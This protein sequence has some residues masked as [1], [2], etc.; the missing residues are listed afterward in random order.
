MKRIS[1]LR[2]EK[3]ITQ[4]KLAQIIGIG[5][6]TLAMYETGGSEPDFATASKL[7]DYFGV[8]VDYL[9]GRDTLPANMQPLDFDFVFVPN[10]ADLAAGFDK[11]A[12]PSDELD[13]IPIPRFATQGYRKEELA[14]FTVKGDSMY[15]DF[16]H[17][18]RILV[19]KQDSVDSGDTAVIIYNNDEATIKKVRYESGQDWLELIPRNPEYQTKRI[20][21][22]DLT[23][24]R[25]I[26]KVL[27]LVWRS[28]K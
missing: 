18:D 16:I 10:V 13:L 24:C 26:G 22:V 20:E 11:I 28:T 3:K 8:S 14:V 23:Q 19:H 12:N 2:K 4:A 15:P 17:G 25:V 5:R 9:L 27:G 1:D 7:A 21:G 6:S